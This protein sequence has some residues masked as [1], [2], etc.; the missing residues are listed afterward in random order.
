MNRDKYDALAN[1]FLVEAFLKHG[2]KANSLTVDFC[3]NLNDSIA[4][5][6]V[7]KLLNDTLFFEQKIEFY[8]DHFWSTQRGQNSLGYTLDYL[9]SLYLEPIRNPGKREQEPLVSANDLAHYLIVSKS[10]DN[11]NKV[12]DTFLHHIDRMVNFAT[13]IPQ[14]YTTIKGY[15]EERIQEEA[16]KGGLYK[17]SLTELLLTT[18]RK[19]GANYLDPS[20]EPDITKNIFQQLDKALTDFYSK[21]NRVD[22]K[23]KILAGRAMSEQN[24]NQVTNKVSM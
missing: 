3:N 23:S 16:L 15:S 19:I 5:Q 24:L 6:Y 17:R 14:T 18:F 7:E 20:K 21:E 13:K 12:Y 10:Y 2:E 22:L 11:S 9:F 4:E 1:Q 8:P